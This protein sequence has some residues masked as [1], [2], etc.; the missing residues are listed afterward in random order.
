M[1]RRLQFRCL[2]PDERAIVR[3]IVT[4][5]QTSSVMHEAVTAI[6]PGI[7]ATPAPAPGPAPSRPLPGSGAP[8]GPTVQPPAAEGTLKITASA[9][10]NPISVN[11]TTTY[12][13]TVQNDRPTADQDLALSVQVEGDGLAITRIPG[14]PVAALRSSPASVDFT[15]VR[16][17]F[18]GEQ[19]P[20]Y[21]IEI[22]G[23]RPGRHKLRITVTSAQAPGGIAAEAETTVTGP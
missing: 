23:M 4:S 19:L 14:S 1:T 17:V 16:Q 21:R 9:Q 20:P 2:N 10:A 15:P 3:A 8:T 22:Q 18:A 6:L 5:Q 11:G 13:I 12:V 7:A